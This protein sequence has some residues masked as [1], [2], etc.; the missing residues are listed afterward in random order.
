MKRVADKEHVDPEFVMDKISKGRIVIPNNAKHD[1]ILPCG[2]GEGLKTKVN[3]NIGTSPENINLGEEV[4]KLNMAVMHGSDTVM[5]LSIGGDLTKIRRKLLK[6]SKVPFGTVPIYE[7]AVKS[8][9]EK[10]SIRKININD[11]LAVLKEQ[12]RDGV[13]FFTIHA[14]LTYDTI[15]NLQEEG[16]VIDIVSRGGAFLAEWMTANDAENPF[17]ESFDDILEI[18]EQWDVTLSLG[19]GMRPGSIIDATDAVQIQELMTLGQLARR[20]NNHGVQVIIEGPGHVPIN[21]VEINVELEKELCDGRPFYVLGPIVTDVA[22]GYDHIAAAIG[23]ALA[24][25]KGADFLCYVTPA[26]HLRLP[27][28]KDVKDGV[29]AARIAAHAAD[30]AKS[31]NSNSLWDR[32]MSEAR[33]K[34]DWNKQIALSIDPRNAKESRLKSMPKKSDVCTMCG[35]FCSMKLVENALKKSKHIKNSLY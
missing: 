10:G 6:Y 29:I 16:R 14:G 21:Q 15:M 23:G 24:A 34:R 1:V 18:A 2:I 33:K 35:D 28:I 5:D 3:A 13:D 12:A 31:V 17:Y 25:A 32:K 20:A 9:C 22:S 7:I 8:I 11:I 26:E 19:D 4:K 30:I 27:S